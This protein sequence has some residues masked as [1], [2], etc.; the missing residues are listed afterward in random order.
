MSWVFLTQ[1]DKQRYLFL[2]DFIPQILLVSSPAN[3]CTYNQIQYVL[4]SN[5]C[6]TAECTC[7][8]GIKYEEPGEITILTRSIRN[9]TESLS[10]WDE[11]SNIYYTVNTFVLFRPIKLQQVTLITLKIEIDNILYAIY[12][13]YTTCSI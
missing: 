13:R 9:I 6:F 5:I 12:T 7:E 8:A 11:I 4:L 3:I 2:F 1:N 10:W